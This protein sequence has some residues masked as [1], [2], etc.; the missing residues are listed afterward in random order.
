MNPGTLNI[1]VFRE[2]GFREHM[3]SYGP[4]KVPDDFTGYS[5]V[6]VFTNKDKVEVLRLDTAN[7]GIIFGTQ[8]GSI[9]IVILEDQTTQLAP[10]VLDYYLNLLPPEGESIRFL[11]G[12]AT[13]S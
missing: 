11:M 4:T 7:G 13:V 5:A 9:D 3:V 1:N 8:R 12:R 2:A 10:G 6:A